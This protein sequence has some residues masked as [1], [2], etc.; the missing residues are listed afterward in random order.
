MPG[1]AQ[2]GGPWR[3]IGWFVALYAAGVAAVF[4]LS[5]IIRTWLGL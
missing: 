5:L 4:A 3:R 1:P 2:S